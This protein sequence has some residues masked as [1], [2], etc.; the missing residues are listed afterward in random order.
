MKI[1]RDRTTSRSLPDLPSDV[2]CACAIPLALHGWMVPDVAKGCPCSGG[3]STG[4][5]LERAGPTQGN[6]HERRVAR[7]PYCLA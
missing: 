3:T 1:D 4:Y 6:R 2:S 7:T 5:R